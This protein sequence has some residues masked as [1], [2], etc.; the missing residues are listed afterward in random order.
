MVNLSSF[1]RYHAART[2]DRI[3]IVYQDQRVTFAGLLARIEKTAGYLA[4]HGIGPDDVVAVM[5]KNSI[6]FLE[7]A[8]AVSHLGAIF[9]PINFR[10]AADEVEYITENAEAKLVFADAE[11]A[12]AVKNIPSAILLDEAAQADTTAVSRN[13][14]PAPMHVR[15]PDQLFRLMYTS[16]TTDRPKGVMHTYSNFYWKCMDHVIALGLTSDERL[17]VTG[18]LYHVGAFDLPGVAVLW[19]GGMLYI[20]R[21]FDVER[22]L[23][24]IA[25]E[26]LTCAWFAPVM[27]GA[28]LA[29][30][31]TAAF[32]VSSIRFVIGGGERTPEA[33]IRAFA[34]Y[35]TKG[36]Y[37][38]GYGLTEFMQRRHADGGRSRNRENRFGWA[39]VASRRSRHSRSAR[40]ALASRGARRDLPPW[41]ENHARLLARSKEDGG[42]L[43]RRLVSYRRRRLSGQ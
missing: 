42:Q 31:K 36:R 34:E 39:R 30:P 27:L 43:R 12:L 3:A 9:L 40:A 20:H 37:V 25:A 17:L 15:R 6:A 11:F 23:Q 16:G 19:V 26:K 4:A 28:I 38:D 35:F 7:I 29:H 33:R 10:L 22:V 8:F 1:I 13:H 18:P 41:A 32:D 21:D 5:M 14:A 24:S 2:P